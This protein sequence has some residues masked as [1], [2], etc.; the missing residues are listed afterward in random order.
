MTTPASSRRLAVV[1]GA[2]MG[3][4]LEL[5]KLCAQDGFELV[6][7]ADQG[8]LDE[9]AARFQRLGAP[10]VDAVQCDLATAQGVSQLV[11][12]IGDREV[13]VVLANAGHGPG[14]AFLDQDF[15]SARHVIDAN[16]TGT[17]DLV[18][19]VGRRMRERG[20]GRILFTGSIA[21]VVPGS[22]QAVYNGTKA[23]I[24]A[25]SVALRS[26]LKDSGVTV[27]V[28]MPGAT[29]THDVAKDGF[30]ALMKGDAWILG[31]RA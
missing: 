3:I 1:T 9:Q 24:D 5:A 8:P 16:L 22:F 23:F 11:A 27:T 7:A 2:S 31:G 25:F 30:E 13:D 28:L 18:H 4:G 17:L 12:C 14:Q 6:I 29:D 19:R 10:R 21:G 26:E 15:R 20:Q